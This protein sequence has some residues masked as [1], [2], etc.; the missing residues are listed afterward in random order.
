[1]P[2][3]IQVFTPL[4]RPI[5]AAAKTAIFFLKVLP[6]LPS[7]PINWVT[8][9]PVIE[10][11]RYPTR[12]GQVEGDLYRPSTEGPHPGIVMCLGVVPFGV[13]HP[14]VPCLEEALARSGFAALI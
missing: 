9:P 3:L 13:D 7:K 1:M 6:M 14:Q 2:N 5:R 4:T 10:R 12:H 11:V 8:S